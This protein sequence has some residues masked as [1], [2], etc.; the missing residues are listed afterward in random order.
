MS[1]K[2]F[3]APMPNDAFIRDYLA[4]PEHLRSADKGAYTVYKLT[5]P[6]GKVYIGQTK[7][8]LARR[9][10]RG[11]NYKRNPELTAD[12]QR[13]GWDNFTLETLRQ[14]ASAKYADAIERLAIIYYKAMS[15][16]GYNKERGG[17]RGHNSAQAK[18]V[19]QLDKDTGEILA[20]WESRCAAGKALHIKSSNIANAAVGKTKSAGGYKWEDATPEAISDWKQRKD[21]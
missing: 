19:F 1:R 15:P 20:L 12:I 3:V 8:S 13:L 21:G 11:K 18:P 16:N 17:I 7:N 10:Q 6:E 14:D 9:C 2:K 4:I 5:S